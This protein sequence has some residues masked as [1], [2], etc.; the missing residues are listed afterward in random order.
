LS[1]DAA[2]NHTAPKTITVP[3]PAPWLGSLGRYGLLAV[4]PVVGSRRLGQ[5]DDVVVGYGCPVV[6]LLLLL[7]LRTLLRRPVH[8]VVVPLLFF[9]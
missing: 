5:T 1:D 7:L 9:R 8:G 6:A 2:P 3:Y 4:G